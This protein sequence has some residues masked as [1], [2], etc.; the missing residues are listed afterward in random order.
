MEYL[1]G[2]YGFTV[3]ATVKKIHGNCRLGHK[4]GD[5]VVF[6]QMEIKGKICNGA[7]RTIYPTLYAFQW[8]AEFPWDKNR[9]ITTVPCGDYENLVV[10]EL[11][12]DRENPGYTE[13]ENHAK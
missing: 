6:D 9:D 12:R 13:K 8:G 5:Q 1:M 3:V 10:F 11:K 4:V 7:L 2:A